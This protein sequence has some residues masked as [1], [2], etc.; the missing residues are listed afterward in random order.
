MESNSKR[1]GAVALALFV[2]IG[3]AVTV[4]ALTTDTETTDTSSVSDLQSSTVVTEPTNDSVTNNIEVEGD[5]NTN[6]STLSNPGTAFKLEFVVNDTDSEQDDEVLYTTDAN[7]TQTSISAAPDYYN[8]S[9]TQNKWG[10]ELEYG[11]GENVTVDARI[12]FNETETDESVHN[13]TYTVDPSDTDARVQFQSNQTNAENKT[14]FG[15]DTSSVP[16]SGE[17]ES[18]GYVN[19]SV[20]VTPDT[21][22][23]TLAIDNQST[24][25]AFASATSAGSDGSLSTV[26][27]VQMNGQ[28]VPVFVGS[29]DASWVSND[30]AYAVLSSDGSEITVYNANETFSDSTASIDVSATGNDAVGLLRTRAMLSNYGAGPI[31]TVGT[32]G[33]AADLNGDPSIAEG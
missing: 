14:L 18:Y 10:D 16:L 22:T 6:T 33:N 2:V 20:A 27:I 29:Q 7:W 32:A 11:G 25:D 1:V 31:K 12:T 30:Q 13:I 21:S 9:V 24:R 28:D 17:T 23:V 26:T 4:T 19:D 5:S 8:L 3:G 15:V